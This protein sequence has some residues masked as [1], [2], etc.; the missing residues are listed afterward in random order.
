MRVAPDTSKSAKFADNWISTTDGKW[1]EVTEDVG[2]DT[3]LSYPI[4]TAKMSTRA[5]G[6][7]LPWEKI[8]V[9]R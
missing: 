9:K 8:G 5:I 2:N 4:I 1:W 7:A 6:L 3:F